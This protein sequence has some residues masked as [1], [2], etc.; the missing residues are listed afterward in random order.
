MCYMAST[1]STYLREPDPL[2]YRAAFL[3]QMVERWPFK[4]M[5]VGSIPTEGAF[6]VFCLCLFV[7]VKHPPLSLFTV[8]T[9]AR[10]GLGPV[11]WYGRLC[12]M[13]GRSSWSA[14]G[15]SPL[16]QKKVWYSSRCTGPVGEMGVI[17]WQTGCE[18][19]LYTLYKTELVSWRSYLLGLLAKI[20]CSI[21]SYQL[22]LWYED[23]VFSR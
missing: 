5:V 11:P 2:M 9:V 18:K 16:V 1:V 15:H 12:A 3:A 23:Q 19:L 10:T 14:L 22:N 8:A 20:K 17:N 7:W 4:P 13:V 6:F 21:C